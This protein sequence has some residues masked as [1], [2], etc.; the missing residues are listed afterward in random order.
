MPATRIFLSYRREDSAGEAGRLSD[1]LAQE[2][3]SGSVFM[4]VD[5]IPLGTD[6]VKRL[7]AEVASCDVLVAVIGSKWLDIRDDEGNRR[8]DDSNDFVRVEIAAALQRD[9]PV[10]PILLDGTKIPRA[11]RLP[12]DLNGLAVREGLEVRH[13]SFHSDIQRLVIQLKGM[14]PELQNGSGTSDI[15]PQNPGGMRLGFFR[16]LPDSKAP[17]TDISAKEIGGSRS[18]RAAPERRRTSTLTYVLMS[19]LVLAVVAITG[20]VFKS[21]CQWAALLGTSSCLASDQTRSAIEPVYQNYTSS[22][23][24]VTIA[25]PSNILTLDTTEQNRRRLTLRDG[26]GQPVIKIWRGAL[27]GQRDVKLARANEF[28]QLEQ[29]NAKPT[30]AG[31]ELEKNWSNWYVLSGVSHGTEYYFRRWYCPDSI[32]SIEFTYDKSVSPMFDGIIMRMTKEM[33]VTDCS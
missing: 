22:D 6:F 25:F 20:L 31:P 5:G 18:G 16:R 4:D 30:L 23:V 10:I 15:S 2:L 17:P 7:T 14:S 1:R 24:G 27:S 32:V 19:C 28:A 12:S 33:V 26:N 21:P 11:D 29:M 3:G 9:I 8:L 13:S